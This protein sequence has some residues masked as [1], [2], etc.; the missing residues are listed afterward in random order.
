[1]HERLSGPG[2]AYGAATDRG[3]LDR[4]IVSGLWPPTSDLVVRTGPVSDSMYNVCMQYFYLRGKKEEKRKAE[5]K[6]GKGN[7]FAPL[8]AALVYIP[9]LHATHIYLPMY[10]HVR[11]AVVD[12]SLTLSPTRACA[13][14]NRTTG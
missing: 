6:K 10:V 11:C 14:G 4:Y 13:R 12:L 1:M 2:R 8:T 9:C 5:E 3:Q 7:R